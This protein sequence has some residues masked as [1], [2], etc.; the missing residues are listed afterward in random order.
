M[1]VNDRTRQRHDLVALADHLQRHREELLHAWHHSVETDPQITTVSSL[2][3]SQFID[4]IPRILDAFDE[5]LRTHGIEDAAVA[6]REGAAEHGVHRWLHGYHYRETMRE[7][8]HLQLCLTAQVEEFA[9]SRP[10]LDS[11]AM[12]LGRRLLTR[13]FFECMVESAAGHVHLA[14]TEAASRLRDLEQVL[15]DVRALETE[16]AELWHEAA[17]DLRG[18]VSAVQLAATALARTGQ[19][20]MR[21]AAAKVVERTARSMTVLLDDLVALARLEA[22]R[23]QRQISAFDAIATVREVCRTFEPLAAER[24][25][26]LKWSA[27][28]LLPVDGDPVKVARIVQN[29]LLNALKYTER[30]GVHVT[31][32][33]RRLGSVPSWRLSVEDTGVGI[34]DRASPAIAKLLRAATREANAVSEPSGELGSKITPLPTALPATQA[35]N[36][37]RGEGVGL[38]IV[39]RL[40]EL[41][42]ATIELDTAHGRG[43]TFLITFP[44]QYPSAI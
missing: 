35:T 7:W 24:G 37:A 10:D 42:D 44:R 23:E 29:L 41:L 22:G 3:R 34:A 33:A 26:F 28:T 8:G 4:H 21:P 2:A 39:K 38:T 43:T 1:T 31:V 11:R 27:P 25:L 6:V 16:R 5:Q 20:A 17:H 15:A 30:G 40:C 9:L 18:N 14:E 12:S 13:L 32:T 36:S 19:P